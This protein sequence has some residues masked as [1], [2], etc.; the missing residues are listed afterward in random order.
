MNIKK[1]GIKLSEIRPCDN[2]SGPLAPLF[3]VVNIRMAVFNRQN[4]NSVL[5]TSQ[6]FGHRSLA[7]AEAMAPGADDAIEV[8]DEPDS[9]TRIFLCQ[10]CYT[11]DI[12]IAVIGERLATRK[13]EI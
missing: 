6:I 10:K 5:G 4:I 11:E 9:V 2:C 8:L 7:L 13:T 1:F 3:S 12:N